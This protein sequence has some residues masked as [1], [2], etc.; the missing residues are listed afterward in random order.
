LVVSFFRNENIVMPPS[1]RGCK[2]CVVRPCVPV[3]DVDDPPAGR[4]QQRRG[5]GGAVTRGAVHPHLALGYLGE[6]GGQ[7]LER[8]VYRSVQ[9]AVLPFE[10]PAHIQDDD[11]AVVAYLGQVGEGPARVAG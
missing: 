1:R 6:A 9:V 5:D 8:D 10:A 2:V 3:V 11:L 7:V 4:G